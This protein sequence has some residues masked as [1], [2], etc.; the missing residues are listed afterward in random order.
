MARP[1]ES[2]EPIINRTVGMNDTDWGHT[3][4]LAGTQHTGLEET[5]SNADLL[6]RFVRAGKL[7]LTLADAARILRK[8]G[9]DGQN[10]SLV[11]ALVVLSEE[12]EDKAP[13]PRA[14]PLRLKHVQR[15]TTKALRGKPKLG[16]KPKV[17]KPKVKA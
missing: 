16:N 8:R 11:R 12:E 17:G 4:T 10:T 13:A 14:A 7:N 3:S 1:R 15:P 9:E 2:E 5:I 6:R